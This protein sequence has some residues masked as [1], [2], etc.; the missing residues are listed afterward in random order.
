VLRRISGPKR[1]EV[2]GAWK[3]T[4]SEELHNLY[5]SPCII[6]NDQVKEEETGRACSM[7]VGEEEC[8]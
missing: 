2:T 1:A 6:R 5:L 3:K 8:I 4:H 7:N